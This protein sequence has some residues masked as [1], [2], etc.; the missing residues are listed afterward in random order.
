MKPRSPYQPPRLASIPAALIP[1][2]AAISGLTVISGL[3]VIPGLA[4]IPGLAEIPGLASTPS[5]S[6][7]PNLVVNSSQAALPVQ[8]R[9]L[10]AAGK[11]APVARSLVARPALA[12]PPQF[13]PVE[14]RWC[15]PDGRCIGLE[16]PRGERQFSFGLQLRPAL[17]PLRGMW[18]DFGSPTLARFWMHRTPE[19][20]DM[21]F[22]RDQRVVAIEAK[23]KPC[24]HLPCRAYGPDQM[25]ESV[26]EL[27]AG[28]AEA[29]G[30][31]VGSEAAIE[32]KAPE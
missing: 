16:V 24:M 30:L 2:L 23:T 32:L 4:I 22:I 8:A 6:I 10:V 18:F 1:R 5:R 12:S 29:L 26:V 27:A 20:L 17:P 19:P 13:L 28:Q 3:A 9:L 11:G 14:A 31:K 15:L 7:T 25:V 21:L